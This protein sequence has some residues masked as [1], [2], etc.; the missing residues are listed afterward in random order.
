M[1]KYFNPLL[2]GFAF[3]YPLKTSENLWF[4]DAFAKYKEGTPG[5][6]GLNVTANVSEIKKKVLYILPLF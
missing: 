4:S 6:N 5:S 3:L 1:R 2:S